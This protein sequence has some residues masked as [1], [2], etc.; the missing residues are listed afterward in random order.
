MV[1]NAGGTTAFAGRDQRALGHGLL[2]L[3]SVGYLGV[4]S[5]SCALDECGPL[6]A[7]MVAIGALT[8][9]IALSTCVFLLLD[10]GVMARLE[11][12]F[13]LVLFVVWSAGIALTMIFIEGAS[14]ALEGLSQP[15]T[16][17]VWIGETL[18]LV[19]LITALFG[20][21][22]PFA[23]CGKRCIRTAPTG[24]D[25]SAFHPNDLLSAS[26][27]EPLEEPDATP[28]HRYIINPESDEAT[29]KPVD[30]V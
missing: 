13:D 2:V 9:L 29:L 6:L 12:I 16:A 27:A 10:V 1:M 4:T 15:M 23:C 8:T 14:A 21:D 26:I 11:W 28:E 24:N 22:G 18:T 19:L 5:R 17:F 3:F 7:I 25:H 30:T 20:A